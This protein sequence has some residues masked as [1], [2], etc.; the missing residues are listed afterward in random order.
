MVLFIYILMENNIFGKFGNNMFGN[1]FFK[2][3]IDIEVF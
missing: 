1:C 2:S 3:E